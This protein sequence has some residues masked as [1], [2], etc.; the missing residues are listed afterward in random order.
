MN[1][2]NST[3]TSPA[4]PASVSTPAAGFDQCRA[5]YGTFAECPLC[6]QGLIPEHAHF[7]CTSCGW[8]DS[9]CD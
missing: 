2:P 1:G 9:C 4:G 7:K 5:R 6:G 8:R 3:Q